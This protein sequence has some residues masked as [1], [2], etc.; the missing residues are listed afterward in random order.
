MTIIHIYDASTGEFIR[1]QELPIDPVATQM[2]G[3]IVYAY[4][5][6][7]TEEELPTFGEHEKIFW[8]VDENTGTGSW[9]V[10]GNYKNV[11]VYNTVTKVFEICS[12]D[13]LPEEQICIDED[14]DKIWDFKLHPEKYLVDVDTHKLIDNPKYELVLELKELERQL[15]LTE[16][17][18]T[19]AL[20]TPIVFPGTGKLYK[21][22]WI[23]DGTYEKL[24]VGSTAGLVQFP[25]QIWDATKLEENMVEMDAQTFGALCAFLAQVQATA[26]NTRKYAQSTLLALIEAKKK[27]IEE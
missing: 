2:K 21:P 19:E 18:Y 24:I 9:V 22:V 8:V 11:E 1:S 13:D 7:S 10:K 27:E 4:F 26:F 12:T 3:E 23:D 16:D 5:P 17:A 15:D 25:I 20:E 6:N 14:S